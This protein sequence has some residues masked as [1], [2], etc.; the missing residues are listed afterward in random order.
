MQDKIA[1]EDKQELFRKAREL[2]VRRTTLIF[3][4][5]A[6]MVIL[7]SVF[8]LSVEK[9]STAGMIFSFGLFVAT[10]WALLK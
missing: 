5:L 4:C 9:I 7:G 2:E 3:L 6:A 1:M 10:L 8:A